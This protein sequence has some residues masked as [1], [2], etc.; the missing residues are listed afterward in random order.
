MVKHIITFSLLFALLC[1]CQQPSKLNENASAITEPVA[2]ESTDEDIDEPIQ[3][4]EILPTATLLDSH[5]NDT[6]FINL[7]LLDPDIQ[8]QFHYADTTN[9]LKTK[10]YPC[11]TCFL[12]YEV[13]Q[14]LVKVNKALK[15]KNLQL[16]FF[17]CYRPRDVQKLMWEVVPDA[18]YVANPYKG[19]SKHNRG[20]AVDL[21]LADAEGNL[22]DMGTGFD[23]FGKE[24]HHDYKELSEQVLQNR[25][26]LKEAMALEGFSPIATEWW[27]Y[28]YKNSADYAVSN[29]A[30]PCP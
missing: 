29:Q 20:G 25:V 30:L 27:H 11:A 24:A 14:A 8:L 5:I 18:R 4:P 12:R 22:L 6:A 28:N 10:V 19:S 21:T 26:T 9:F 3:E 16:V 2:E 23:H 15:A 13:A 1:A 7:A 17:D